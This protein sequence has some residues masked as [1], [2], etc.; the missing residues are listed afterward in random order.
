MVSP[1][2]LMLMKLALSPSSPSSAPMPMPPSPP[3]SP[4]LP[5]R[6][7]RIGAITASVV[8]EPSALIVAASSAQAVPRPRHTTATHSA[9]SNTRLRCRGGPAG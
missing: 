6:T 7:S 8:T 1:P 2:T 5:V 9:A 4:L 3:A